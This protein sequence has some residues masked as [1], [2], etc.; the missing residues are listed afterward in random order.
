MSQTVSPSK[1]KTAIRCS[2]PTLHRWFSAINGHVR[3]SHL[4]VSCLYVHY[5]KLYDLTSHA[6]FRSWFRLSTLALQT[7]IWVKHHDV[8]F[9]FGQYSWMHRILMIMAKCCN[10]ASKSLNEQHGISG[11]HG[12]W[13]MRKPLALT[14][15][16]T[17]MLITDLLL[18]YFEQ[19]DKGRLAPLTCHKIQYS[20]AY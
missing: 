3:V 7:D 17:R 8:E 12:S 4:L 15:A 5:R 1:N 16:A 20:Q 11:V 18:F 9:Y 10:S 13:F 19:N 2:K 6:P 14:L